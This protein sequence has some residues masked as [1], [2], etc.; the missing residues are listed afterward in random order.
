MDEPKIKE[1]L[2]TAGREYSQG[3][4]AE[5]IAH[6]QQVLTLDRANQKA[7]EGIRMAQLL[8]VNWEAAESD[9]GGDGA[10]LLTTEGTDAETQHKIDV[11]IARVRELMAG[12]RYQEAFEGC[13][14]LAELAPGVAP[15]SDLLEEVT[16]AREAQPFVKERLERANRFI[17][18]GKNKE[19]AEEARNVLSVDR[20]NL[21]AKEILDRATGGGDEAKPKT[22]SAF[23]V[24]RGGKAPP[25]SPFSGRAA[26]DT[27]ALLAQFEFEP[28]APAGTKSAKPP[29]AAKGEGAL[30]I[31]LDLSPPDAAG[32]GGGP[33]SDAKIKTLIE[34]GEGLFAKKKF[35]AAIEVWSRVYA[36]D[37]THAQAGVLIDRAKAVLEDLSRQVDETYF[38]GVDAL[39]SGNLAEARKHLQEVLTIHPEHPDAQR[40]LQQVEERSK[41]K[42]AASAPQARPATDAARP[43]PGAPPPPSPLP[44]KTAKP[45][46]S[47]L[48]PPS[49]AAQEAAAL[50]SSSVP[51][52]ISADEHP[53]PA[54]KSPKEHTSQPS[55][56]PGVMKRKPVQPVAKSSMPMV[57]VGGAIALVLLLGAGWFL[58][59]RGGSSAP[60]SSEPHAIPAPAP[61]EAPPPE[62]ADAHGTAAGTAPPA[63]RSTLEVR[64]GTAPT[65]AASAAAEAAATKKKLDGL[66]KEGRDLVRDERF[67]EAVSVFDQVLSLDP[68]NLDAVDLKSKA[69]GEAQKTAKFN[70]ELD[71]A[72]A[73]FADGDW[74]GSLY[75]LYRLREEHKEM[76]TLPRFIRNANYNW[77]V[78]ALSGFEVDNAIEHFKDALEMA[79]GDPAIQ[80]N[81]EFAARYRR[82]GRDA[83]FDSF[84][85]SLTM[86][87]L[88]EK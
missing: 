46:P 83:A 85:K 13:Q 35:Q 24:D 52:A 32:A 23:Q 70:R 53:R 86:K 69:A 71:S 1:L 60:S 43:S 64:P 79:P 29:A 31:D 74:A 25:P 56:S 50:D 11:G 67:A 81:T 65:A 2:D 44:S 49:K 7:K 18:Q 27:D 39:E 59:L 66:M 15:V 82:H 62:P 10:V 61:V 48:P 87:S 76:T 88:D 33:G 78:E 22:Q 57:L 16:Q 14:L 73:A 8:V 68:A 26:K 40:Y 36:I 41:G 9:P 28:T 72:K 58:L 6:W 51:L 21:R 4:Y 63:P 37:R 45:Q 42:A 47:P 20:M 38:R 3:K 54:P 55:V 17:A 12:G 80:K 75:K 34:D 84:V 5:A 77:G 19:A 30:P